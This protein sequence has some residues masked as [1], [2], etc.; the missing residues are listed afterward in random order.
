MIQRVFYFFG[1]EVTRVGGF[2]S[3]QTVGTSKKY[4]GTVYIHIAV[5]LGYI[6]LRIQW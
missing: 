5:F 6:D 4:P 1:H 3:A 2:L